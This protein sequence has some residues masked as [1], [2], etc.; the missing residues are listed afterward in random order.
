MM[1]GHG[2]HNGIVNVD[3]REEGT[4]ISEDSHSLQVQLHNFMMKDPIVFDNIFIVKKF[5]KSMIHTLT[6]Y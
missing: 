1:N 4:E 6:C 5:N 3:G 2:L